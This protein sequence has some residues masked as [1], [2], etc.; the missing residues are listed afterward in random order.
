MSLSALYKLVYSAEVSFQE[1]KDTKK[2]AVIVQLVEHNEQSPAL[3]IMP[4]VQ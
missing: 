3:I 2:A 4:H 1:E